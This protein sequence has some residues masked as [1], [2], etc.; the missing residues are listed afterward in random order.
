M[1][2]KTKGII[3]R[4]VKYGETSLIVTVFTELFG[5]QTYMLNGVRTS[6]KSS[7]KANLFQPASIL[8]LVVYHN[9]QKNLQRIREFKWHF[10]YQDI[11]DDVLKNCVALYMVELLQKCLKQPEANTDLFYFCEDALM[12]LD[13]SGKTSAANFTL[14]FALHLPHFLGFRMHD[15]Y[16][17]KNQW[18]DLQEGVFVAEQP[19][20][21]HFIDGQLAKLTSQLL[22]VM[23]PAE[24]ELFKLNQ[25]TRRTL[26]VRLTDYYAL[27]IHDF[28][29]MRTLR[30]LGEV[31]S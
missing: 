23:Q 4:T 12:Q 5:V 20:H 26:L 16:T 28:G 22:K 10:L 9:E 6:G 21:P 29:Q 11:L 31:L 15:N 25:E 8:D 1:T 18:L 24:L 3:L 30:V 19:A 27:H 2:H 13:R 17:E 7:S 14:F